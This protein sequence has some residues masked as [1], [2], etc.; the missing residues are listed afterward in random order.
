MQ[1]QADIQVLAQAKLKEAE[2]LFTNG[3]FDGAYYLGGYAVELLLKAMVCKSQGN[4]KN[5]EDNPKSY[6][7]FFVFYNVFIYFPG[8]HYIPTF[9]T[10]LV[11]R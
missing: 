8:N 9:E 11:L 6:F 5:Q 10:V 4:S 1:C 2:C 7:H 3:F